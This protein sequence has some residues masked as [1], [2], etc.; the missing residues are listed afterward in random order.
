MEDG[1]PVCFLA[2]L[3]EQ[4]GYIPSSEMAPSL[5]CTDWIDGISLLEMEIVKGAFFA[6]NPNGKLA[7][8]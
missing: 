2:F 8:L 5:G 3:S 7:N 4:V 6:S 1:V